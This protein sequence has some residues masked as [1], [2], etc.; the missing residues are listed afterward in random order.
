M[1]GA[2]V[3]QDQESIRSTHV[4]IKLSS[5]VIESMAEL[6][7][8][9]HAN[10]TKIHGDRPPCIKESRLQNRGRKHD[11]I[12]NRVVVC[13]DLF[14]A[15]NEKAHKQKNQSCMNE[16]TRGVQRKEYVRVSCELHK[17][18]RSG[19]VTNIPAAESCTTS[20]CR[21]AYPTLRYSPE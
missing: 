15:R 3:I 7:P 6:V 14:H 20:V 17:G 11:L 18:M 13:I 19:R 2:P 10:T 16:R 5:L 12:A 9:N 8:H 4:P 21:R 1:Y